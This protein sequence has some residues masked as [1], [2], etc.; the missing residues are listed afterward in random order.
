MIKENK[1]VQ[2]KPQSLPKK[3][4]GKKKRKKKRESS[5]VIAVV[6][7]VLTSLL[8]ILGAIV[9]SSDRVLDD[10][11]LSSENS[12]LLS[13]VS[14]DE[15]GFPVT[16]S[17]NDI[18]RVESFSSRIFVLGKKIL[19]CISDSGKVKFNRIFTFTKPDMTVSENYGLVYDRASSKY[20]I[21]NE[22]GVIYE[23]ESENK[24]HIITAKINNNGDVAF[25]TKS[26]DSACRV[27]LVDKSGK[28][29]YIWA[30]ADEYG[31]C[32]DLSDD[33]KE[34]VC[35]TVGSENGT[36]Y[37]KLYK[38]ETYS[39]EIAAEQ[40]LDGSAVVDVKLVG[41]K[42]VVTADNCR[43]VFT[44]RGSTIKDDH[45][46]ISESATSF[47]SDK[48]GNTVVVS[49]KVGT[50]SKKEIT[51]YN[52]NNDITYVGFTD[53]DVVDVICRG[54]KVYLLT[55]KA[56]Y[57]SESDGSFKVVGTKEISGEGLVICKSRLYYYS[58][59]HVDINS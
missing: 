4:T 47:Y 51:V 41:R 27:Y 52:K 14:A 57:E 58:T 1:N 59:G 21:F 16:F 12:E 35:G 22:K 43:S 19:T 29:L 9:F 46:A 34:I 2:R 28:V 33:G 37:S 55:D 31:V 45:I 7:I 18:I 25:V 36:V 10:E 13:T 15:M 24:K 42:A 48:S 54:K 20:F 3:P 49:D 11:K 5:G 39:E 17:N 44:F 32:I 40:R 56:I 50:I 53:G 30:C 8:I 26:D 6:I 23:G 38:L